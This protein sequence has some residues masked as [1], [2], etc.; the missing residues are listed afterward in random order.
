[1]TIKITAFWDVTPC[2]LEDRYQLF[3]ANSSLDIHS[4]KSCSFTLMIEVALSTE[5][6][7]T[8]YQTTLLNIPL[9]FQLCSFT[10]TRRHHDRA[11]RVALPSQQITL[12]ETF[13]T[14]WLW[15]LW[16]RCHTARGG[17]TRIFDPPAWQRHL[18][19]LFYMEVLTRDATKN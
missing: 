12:N 19:P 3:V 2:S 15:R 13:H 17:R 6:L 11:T 18:I 14:W 1:M 8:M 5:S 10:Y 7:L 4:R 9:V 16:K